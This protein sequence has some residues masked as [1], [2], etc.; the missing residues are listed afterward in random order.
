[1]NKQQPRG[2]N[3]PL[4]KVQ[5]LKNKEGATLEEQFPNDAKLSKGKKA[6]V[7]ENNHFK[8][9]PLEDVKKKYVR[10]S[11]FMEI[12]NDALELDPK[13]ATI[14]QFAHRIRDLV[15]AQQRES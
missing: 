3:Q 12:L 10:F 11:I 4:H 6:E 8:N 2:R 13:T 5:Q 7:H 1:M 9:H 15:Y 14:E